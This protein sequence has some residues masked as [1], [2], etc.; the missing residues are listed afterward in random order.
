MTQ[1]FA[2]GDQSIGDS[3]SASVLPM[4]NDW[5]DSGLISISDDWFD[6]LAFEGTLKN[7][8]QHHNLKASILWR[9]AE[10]IVVVQ[11]LTCLTLKRLH[12][13]LDFELWSNSHIYT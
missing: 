1:F 3:A 13:L 11:L 9:S 10:E 7:L 2:S 5:N 8:L 12:Q 6:L 4:M